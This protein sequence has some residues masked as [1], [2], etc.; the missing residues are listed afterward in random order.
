MRSTALGLVVLG[1]LVLVS[2]SS[3]VSAQSKASA[4]E[5]AWQVQSVSNPRPTNSPYNNPVG[6]IVFSGR[7]FASVGVGN[8]QRAAVGD[9]NNATADQLRALWG[10]IVADA[11]TFAVS[12]NTMKWVRVVAKNPSRDGRRELR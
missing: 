1:V 8:T 2:G 7:H 9:A 11:G 3:W 5:G 10:P 4:L 12:G 6:L